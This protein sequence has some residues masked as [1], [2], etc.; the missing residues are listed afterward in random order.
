[1]LQKNFSKQF[2]IGRWVCVIVPLEAKVIEPF[3]MHSS[4]EAKMTEDKAE[5][6]TIPSKGTVCKLKWAGLC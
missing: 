6:W 4:R 5:K 3:Y 2:L 1:M